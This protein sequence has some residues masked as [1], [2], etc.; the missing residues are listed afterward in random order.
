MNIPVIA[1]HSE[2]PLPHYE[3][4]GAS[5]FDLHAM[6]NEPLQLH[7]NE[8]IL[9]PTGLSMAIPA[10]YE[11]QIRP[12]SGMAFKR[13]LTVLNTPGTIDADY[14][15]EIKVLAYN[16]S[17]EMIEISPKERIAQAVIAPII[18]A[19]FEF[20]NELPETIRGSGGFGHTGT[21]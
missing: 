20:V 19:T 14:R 21:M 16:A 3:T 2:V 12:R 4:N 9:V 17:N 7:P 13:G 11:A 1:L 8:R 18:Q 10:G 15:G 6:I 5:G